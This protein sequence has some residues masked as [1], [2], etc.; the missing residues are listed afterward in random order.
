[1]RGFR[2][3]VSEAGNPAHG[4][5]GGQQRNGNW[6]FCEAIDAQG[7][8]RLCKVFDGRSGQTLSSGEYVLRRALPLDAGP[9]SEPAVVNAPPQQLIFQGFDGKIIS[10]ADGLVLLPDGWIDYPKGGGHGEKKQYEL[11]QERGETR[12][13]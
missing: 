2:Q 7:Q 10:A 3:A 5:V 1:M 13:Y 8:R 9:R 6:I 12:P 11:G 4:C